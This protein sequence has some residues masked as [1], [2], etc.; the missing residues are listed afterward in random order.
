MLSNLLFSS[1]ILWCTLGAGSAFGKTSTTIHHQLSITLEPESHTIQGEDIITVSPPQSDA[2]SQSFML[3]PHLRVTAIQVGSQD[4]P[5]SQLSF[6]STDHAQKVTVPTGP[7]KYLTMRVTYEGIIDDT[8]KASTGLR[9]VRP[10]KTMGHIGTKGIYLTYE[11]FWYPTWEDSLP[12]FDVTVNMPTPYRVVTQGEEVGIETHGDRQISTWKIANPSEALTLAANQFVVNTKTW[13]SILLATYLYQS[14]AHLAQEYLDAT[15][16]YLELY[17]Q[18]L[19]PYP[20]KK[21]AVVENFFPSGLGLPSFT[22]LGQGVVR[23]GYTQP[24]SLGHEIVHSWLG[25]SVFNNLEEGNWVEGLTTY[26]SNYYYDEATGNLE[27]ALKTRKRMMDEYNLYAVPNK[28]YPIKQFH[29]KEVRLDNAIGY[30]KTALV[31]HML[32][33]EL[34]DTAFFLGIRDLIEEGTG[35]FISW[36]DLEEIFSRVGKSDLGWFFDQWI[37]RPGAL[38]LQVTKLQVT[39]DRNNP[40]TFTV[41]GMIEQGSPSYTTQL[42]ITIRLPDGMDQSSRVKLNQTSQAFRVSVLQQPQA[43]LLDPNHDVLLRLNRDQL[44][45]MLNVWETDTHRIL[46]LPKTFSE[47]EEQAFSAPMRRLQHQKNLDILHTNSLNI[48]EDASYLIFGQPGRQLLESGVLSH[49]HPHVQSEGNQ[50]TIKDQPFKGPHMAFLISCPHPTAP[51][52]VMTLFFGLSP[53]AIKPMARL[54]FFYGWDSY[55]VYE[56]GKVIARGMFQPVH[57]AREFAIPTP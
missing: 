51:G 3:N 47:E 50:V 17:T 20:F 48:S 46:V 56:K 55:L 52:H 14:E 22:L 43:L 24:Y 42:P 9:F 30:Q 37:N 16:K 32:R 33:Q 6:E 36:K 54:L 8:P 19:G 26:L 13:N 10:D 57:S 34:G 7:R 31:F 5:L 21:F 49:C 12:T 1:L 11:T 4:I 25:N 2:T 23:R 38:S 29:H 28:E 27:K 35:K 41:R 18:L 40:E 53:Q 44:P 45:P 15:Q 39:E